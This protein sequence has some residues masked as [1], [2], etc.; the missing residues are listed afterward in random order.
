MRYI[1]Y[2]NSAYQL[3]NVLNLH[4][5]RKHAGFENIE[6]YEAELLLLNAYEG[7]RDIADILRENGTFSRVRLIDK[8]YNKGPFH[9]LLTLLDA[10][11]PAFY[12]ASKHR[13]DP[14]EIRNRFD[15]VSVPKYSPIVD[16]IWRLNRKADLEL[17][18]EGIASYHL[19]FPLEPDSRWFRLAEKLDHSRHFKDYKSLY[20]VDKSFY[21]FTH[22]E[23]VIQIPA[24]D[25]DYLNELRQQL[26]GFDQKN[27]EKRDIYWLS[28]FLNNAEYNVMVDQVLQELLPYRD[29]VLFVQHPRKYLENRYEFKEAEKKQIWELQLLNMEDPDSKLYISIHSTACFSAKM[30][31]DQEPY[32]IL[33]YKLGDYEVAHVTREFEDIVMKFKASYRQPQKVM[34]PETMEEYRECLR[35]F[36]QG[37]A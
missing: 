9:S 33:Y 20:V 31:F 37:E 7:A 35:K 2:C 13:I 30:L 23:R 6:N 24:M 18:E 8:A 19:D 32:V 29:R 12:L 15:V 27:D 22:P 10:F 5:Q 25:K 17:F 36:A 21:S 34:I 1:Y 16:Q 4:W 3:L 26:A 11:F 28:Q 14:K